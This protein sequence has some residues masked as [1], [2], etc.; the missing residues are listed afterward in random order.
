MVTSG[1]EQFLF[2]TQKS[3][4]E[5]GKKRMKILVTGGAGF[6]GSHLTDRL[7]AEGHDVAVYDNLM[8]GRLNNLKSAF[9][10]DRF[11]FIEG[12][13]L[14]EDQFQNVLKTNHFDLIFHFAANSDIA[15][16]HSDPNWDFDNTFRTTYQVLS[17]MRKY[18]IKELVFASSSA[19]YGET[20]KEIKEDYGPLFPHSHYG[21]AKL[22]SE[23]WIAG[24]CENYGIR[25]WIPRFPNVIGERATHGVI[26]DFI[27]K[28]KKNPEQL[29]VLGNGEQNKPYLYVHDLIDALFFIWK[30]AH[31]KI[32]V[33]N[34]GTG[35]RTKVREIAAIVIE[36]MK[37]NSKILYTGGNRGWIGDVPEFQYDLGKIEKLGWSAKHTS[38]EAV[39]KAV[40]SILENDQCSL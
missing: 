4:I 36:E 30:N 16:S 11:Q 1:S 37:L 6:I 8:L 14:D 34:I 38:T 39:R 31:E 40:R 2:K 5:K 3:P 33:F 25:A 32:N 24:F 26:L 12:D 15:K 19:I 21:A 17:G 35:S 10:N 23:A 29:E 27:R 9:R 22:A 28:L 7:L 13:I 18:E 20:A